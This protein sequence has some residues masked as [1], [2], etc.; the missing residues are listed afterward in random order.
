[1]APV[2]Q[3]S[4]NDATQPVLKDS[5]KLPVSWLPSGGD[6]I[7]PPALKRFRRHLLDIATGSD[8]LYILQCSSEGRVWSPIS[9]PDKGTIVNALVSQNWDF[10]A[11]RQFTIKGCLCC[12]SSSR[13]YTHIQGGAASR[14]SSRPG[15]RRCGLGSVVMSG[16]ASL[17]LHKT[18]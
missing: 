12:V 7:F 11:V 4:I 3:S 15:L 16:C 5:A 9:C 13:G 18:A 1:M 8:V 2:I 6:F 10:L 17:S 14:D